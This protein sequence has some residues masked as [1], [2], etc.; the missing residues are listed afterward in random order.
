MC[1]C[2]KKRMTYGVRSSHDHEFSSFWHI[3]SYRGINIGTSWY[4][5]QFLLLLG[6]IPFYLYEYPMFIPIFI[7]MFNPH[8]RPW[9]HQFAEIPWYFTRMF[10]YFS[11]GPGSLHRFSLQVCP[12]VGEGTGAAVLETKGGWNPWW[13]VEGWGGWGFEIRKKGWGES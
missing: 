10:W 7:P 9:D 2:K 5:I 11:P 4:I 8:F 6:Y 13:T 12:V 1:I 3:A